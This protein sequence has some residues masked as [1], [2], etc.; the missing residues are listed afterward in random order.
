MPNE[1]QQIVHRLQPKQIDFFNAVEGD[2]FEVIGY[3][4]AK[5]GGKSH[6][7]REIL[8]ARRIKYPYTRGYLF[9]KTSDELRQNHVY[10]L[11]ETHPELKKY[12]KWSEMALML[13]N[14]SQLL[15][16]YLQYWHDVLNYQGYP[17]EDIGIDEATMHEYRVYENL[18]A[19]NR[20][21]NPNFKPKFLL[22][23]NPGGVGHGWVKKKFIKRQFEPGED[24]S[25]HTF[26]SAKVY[27]NKVLMK[28][29][30]AYVKRLKGLSP[31]MRKA[32]LEGSFDVFEGQ[33]FPEWLAEDSH[34][35]PYHVVPHE[36]PDPSW[37]VFIGLDWG[38]FPGYFAAVWIAVLPNKRLY[39]FREA[40]WQRKHGYDAAMQLMRM[41]EE[42][43]AYIKAGTDLWSKRNN[44]T[45]IKEDHPVSLYEEF[46]RAGIPRELMQPA[47]TDRKN[48]WGMLRRYLAPAP[49][50]LP[51]LQVSSNC[52]E[53]I[54][55]LPDMVHAE[56]DPD[57]MESDPP[58]EDHLADALRYA[59][60]SRPF[61]SQGG[62]LR[63]EGMTMEE[64]QTKTFEV[65][66][67]GRMPNIYSDLMTGDQAS[68]E[69]DDEIFDDMVPD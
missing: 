8:L 18:R 3:G 4:G 44:V 36:K 25:L 68:L 61:R 46:I 66:E 41:S 55:T 35:T 42:P 23:F 31:Q 67:K 16:R 65:D 39:V 15:F 52:T 38:Y 9:R 40:Y 69:N 5:G 56:H 58:I 32:F 48:G 11:L 34:G 24:P 2:E 12:F 53:L 51:W 21:D 63:T 57:D 28:N 22:T 19:G 13:P 45:G 20:T 54:R 10:P 1:I 43:V 6:S 64:L 59:I 14:G 7:M 26:I 50:E 49:D 60:M 47:I 33:F 29:D 37:K 27:D 30:P 62:T 17:L